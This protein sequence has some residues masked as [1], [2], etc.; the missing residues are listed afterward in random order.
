MYKYLTGKSEEYLARLIS[1]VSSERARQNGQK[2]KTRKFYLNFFVLFFV[3][4][5]MAIVAIDH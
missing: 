3:F 2:L 5:I 1:V 4:S